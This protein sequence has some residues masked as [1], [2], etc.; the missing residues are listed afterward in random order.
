MP[1]HKLA[2]AKT[3]NNYLPLSKFPV[4]PGFKTGIP[5]RRS[6]TPS[7]PKS[8][9]RAAGAQFMGL[10]NNGYIDSRMRRHTK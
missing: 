10:S 6:G 3:N 8:A 2:T 1:P 7:L 4:K 9:L 5:K